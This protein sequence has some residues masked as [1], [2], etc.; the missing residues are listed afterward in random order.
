M[1]VIRL[2][3]RFW[4]AGCKSWQGWSAGAADEFGELCDDCANVAFQMVEQGAPEPKATGGAQ[5]LGKITNRV[6]VPSGEG[7]K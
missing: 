1:T 4:C 6:S 3:R 2:E 5:R 7:R